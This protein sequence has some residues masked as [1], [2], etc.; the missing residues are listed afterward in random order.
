MEGG[1][2]F[3][4]LK[5]RLTWWHEMKELQIHNDELFS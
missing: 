3:R 4:W 1:W 5:V 2:K